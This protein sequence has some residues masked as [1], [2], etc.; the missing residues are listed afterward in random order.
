MGEVYWGP[1]IVGD[2]GLVVADGPETVCQPEAV[3]LPPGTDWFGIGTGWGTYENVLLERIGSA[4]VAS[5]GEGLPRAAAV[6][7]LAA[8]AVARGDVLPA[9]QALPVYLRDQVADKPG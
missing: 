7:R 1:F 8:V 4:L 9:E 5:D 3:P 6:A 2:D